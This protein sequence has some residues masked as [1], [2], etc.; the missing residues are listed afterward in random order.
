MS[1]YSTIKART[2]NLSEEDVIGIARHERLEALYRQ[3]HASISEIFAA[4]FGEWPPKGLELAI[5]PR[6]DVKIRSVWECLDEDQIKRQREF[7]REDG[8]R[9]R[10]LVPA[11]LE[12]WLNRVER[13]I[14]SDGFVYFRSFEP[15]RIVYLK[16]RKA[17]TTTLGHE[18]THVIQADH[19]IAWKRSGVFCREGAEDIGRAF[20]KG[21]Y[22]VTRSQKGLKRLVLELS[23][24][25]SF[26]D[27]RKGHEI[28]AR[29]HSVLA[30]GYPFWGRLPLSKEE[31]WAAM[32]AGGV[33]PTPAV[34][35]FLSET[36]VG[37]RACE[38]FYPIHDICGAHDRAEAL[39]GE[40]CIEAFL[41]MP[42]VFKEILPLTPLTAT[43]FLSSAVAAG[44]FNTYGRDGLSDGREIG[45]VQR[46]LKK[47]GAEDSFWETLL[48]VLYGDLLEMYGDAK[49]RE[50]MGLGV[51]GT[52]TGT[53]L[54]MLRE[55]SDVYGADDIKRW[56][57]HLSAEQK[58]EACRVIQDFCN[59]GLPDD[60]MPKNDELILAVL[61]EDVPNHRPGKPLGKS[62]R[63]SFSHGCSL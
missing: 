10:L 33:E 12:Q 30:V 21:A 49:G 61:Q 24:M 50:R 23:K 11:V 22:E 42:I 5:T 1:I 16:R 54:Q 51:N 6:F 28:Q 7:Y 26:S 36:E 3:G 34:K 32:W 39:S 55:D 59:D 25:C 58:K 57:G 35:S 45:C 20:W 41:L 9:L 18:T 31:L 62:E 48:P 17:K 47:T 27:F 13:A 15:K 8:D 19:E 14:M 37:R 40:F 43:A 56:A 29:M 38:T 52:L 60:V 44:F 4:D 2:G 63:D 53:W 46:D